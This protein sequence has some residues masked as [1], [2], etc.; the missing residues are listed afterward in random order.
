MDRSS[1]LGNPFPMGPTA[2][3]SAVCD[4]C[5]RLFLDNTSVDDA[6]AAAGLPTVAAFA[7]E[8]AHRARWTAIDALV[9]RVIAGE[10]IT[11]LC[12]CTPERCHASSIAECVLQRARDLRCLNGVARS[13]ATVSH[14]ELDEASLTPLHLFV[15]IILGGKCT[16]WRARRNGCSLLRGAS[17]VHLARRGLSPVRAVG[18]RALPRSHGRPRLLF[19]SA[20]SARHRRLWCSHLRS[21]AC[22]LAAVLRR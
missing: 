18:G 9:T 21:T 16:H 1:A 14:T 20:G 17:P 13:T 19:I 4:A 2:S 8:K 5:E 10:S 6:A 3:R 22:R 7:T 12:H 15:P 11:L